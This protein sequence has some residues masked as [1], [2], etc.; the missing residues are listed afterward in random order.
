[1]TSTP[2][3]I[4]VRFSQDLP[5]ALHRNGVDVDRP[6][7]VCVGGAAGMSPEHTE[8]LQATFRDFVAPALDR[9][10]AAVVDGGTDSGV[11][12]LVG[13]ARSEAGSAFTLIGVAADGTVERPGAPD[14]EDAAPLEPNHTHAV[15]VPGETWG[16]ETPWISAV[17]AHVAGSSPSVTMLINGGR[18]ALNDAQASLD[19]GRPLLVVAGSGRSADEIAGARAGRPAAGQAS[20]IASSP[21]TSIV[22]GSDGSAILAGIAGVLAAPGTT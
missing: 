2:K 10:S 11:M 5:D 21:L 16:D 1:M 19:A 13:R 3:L 7:L 9:W 18:I 20:A 17:S 6:V 15:L 12:R 8:A 4:P 22:D 14:R